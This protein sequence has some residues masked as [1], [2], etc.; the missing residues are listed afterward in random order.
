MATI[1]TP[2]HRPQMTTVRHKVFKEAKVEE[3]RN[4]EIIDFKFDS[5]T[6]INRT[7][8]LG[9]IK[10]ASVAVNIGDAD[11]IVAGGRGVGKA[12]GFKLLEE[13]ADIL[14]GVV[15]ASRAAVDSEWISY[16]HQIGQTGKTVAP[17]VYI[18]CGISGQVQH[19][20]GMS[21]S[22]IIIAI[23]KDV[24][25]SMMQTATYALEGD[26]YEILP[27]IIREIKSVRRND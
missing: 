24:S 7:K 21:S 19:T 17:K 12:E 9:F 1:L 16:S 26:M 3:K 6:L 13:L 10:D 4:G 11:I 27:N 5:Q 20:V 18:A 25:C 22:D 14:G 8:F 2:G 15:G 23:N